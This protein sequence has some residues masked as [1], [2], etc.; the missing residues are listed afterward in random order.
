[1]IPL[2]RRAIAGDDDA[3]LPGRMLLRHALDFGRGDG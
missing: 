1:L 2:N 3:N